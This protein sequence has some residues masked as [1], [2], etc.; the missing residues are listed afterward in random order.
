VNRHAFVFVLGGLS[1]LGGL[2]LACAH[3]E[4]AGPSEDAD[5]GGIDLG[6]VTREGG[7]RSGAK[8]G[9]RTDAAPTPGEDA[10]SRN[11]RF[12]SRL[13]SFEPGACAGFGQPDM[14]NIVLG[15]P[16]GAGD[17]AGSLDVVSLGKGGTIVLA[18]EPE[19]IV[20]GPGVDFIVFEN[21]FFT[22]GD[23][24]K[25]YFELAEVSVSDDGVTWSTFPCVTGGPAPYGDCAGWRPVYAN[26]QSNLAEMDPAAAG[27]DPYDLATIGVPRAR[28]V[29]IQDRTS[30]RCTSQGPDT[31]GFDLDAIAALHVAV[32]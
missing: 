26:E 2:G 24:T 30:Q 1:L 32:P 11:V 12:A 28:F 25:P 27:G 23:P 21:A 7:V 6:E 19:A 3:T 15:P 14:P 4:G 13:V 16:H 9:Q 18:F 22:A 10:A 8:P 31:N 17:G 29:R 5:G 20:D